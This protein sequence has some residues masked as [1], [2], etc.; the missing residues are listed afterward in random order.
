VKVSSL[1]TEKEE[2]NFVV[3]M[4]IN[5]SGLKIKS[6]RA[7]LLT[8]KLINGKDSTELQSIGIYGRKRYFYYIRNG[9]S[10]LSGE[11]ELSFRKAEMPQNINYRSSVPYQ[12]WME[13]AEILLNSSTYG[14]CSSMLSEERET[15]KEAKKKEQEI[16]EPPQK[17]FFPEL[18]FVRPQAEKQKSR[19]LSGTAYIDFPLDES[20]IRPDYHRNRLELRKIE[21]TIDS[22]R[23][24]R[25]ITITSLSLKGFA[26][27]EGMIDH[28]T[29]LAMRRTAALKKYLREM[30][31]FD[32]SFIETD[33]EPEDWQGLRK[34]IESSTLPHRSEILSIIDGSREP[35]VK[36]WLIKSQ[37]KE[38][39]KIMVRDCYPSLRRTEYR[40]EY[41]IRT[42]SDLE[43]IRH[44]LSTQ[45]QKLSLNEL[46][47]VAQ[48]EEP[49]SEE[50]VEVFETAVRLFP[51]DEVANINAANA[52]MRRG[53]LVSAKRYLDRA[54]VSA[55]AEYA[56][57]A[58]YILKGDYDSARKCLERASERGLTQ[59]KKTLEQLQ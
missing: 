40:I 48:V 4:N 56:R 5:L 36:E 3:R 32:G 13:G 27:P 41:T 22:V 39:Y 46:Y 51:T 12:E 37:Y 17:K 20:V 29:D 44:I 58:Y 25:D 19:T 33:Y 57:G 45:P 1:K 47:L 6:N 43:E 49:G 11:D 30:Y 18:I 8:P 54:G 55:E 38:D 21:E 2:G 14:C 59:A 50:F 10:L 16:V 15:L 52:E 35:D 34:Y 28:N 42:F 24:D 26:S 53:D 7:V 9:E 31:D 23:R